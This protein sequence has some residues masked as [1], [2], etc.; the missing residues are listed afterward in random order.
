MEKNEEIPV[1]VSDD[2]HLDETDK[3]CPLC[4]STNIV[5]D[6]ETEERVCGNCG[7]VLGTELAQGPEWRSYTQEE[8]QRRER[9]GPPLKQSGSLDLSTKILVGPDASGK[10]LTTKTLYE[11]RKLSRIQNRE[12]KGDTEKSL[13]FALYQIQKIADG[14]DIMPESQLRE[15]IATTYRRARQAGLTIGRE[16]KWI[17]AASFYYVFREKKIAR[18]LEEIEQASDVP[19]KRIAHNYKVMIKTFETSMPMPISNPI[20]Y[21]SKIAE[22]IGISGKTQGKAIEIIIEAKNK[23]VAI[24]KDSRGV[25][26]CALY[27]ACL[28]NHEEVL[29]GRIRRPVT[30]RELAEAA[31]VSEVTVRKRFKELKKGLDLKVP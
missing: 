30:Q 3:K 13:K 9:T 28:Q 6:Y 17:V 19:K 4:G 18:T 27:I 23:R 11:I 10:R 14:L 1:A 16:I 24:A 26:A 12:A 2:K 15:D 29:K 21:V 25:A 8:R 22:Q 5:K 20:S 31:E 7:F